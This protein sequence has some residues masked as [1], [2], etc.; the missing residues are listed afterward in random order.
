VRWE[1]RLLLDRVDVD[2]VADRPAHVRVEIAY[3]LRRTG[4]P[5][6]VGLTMEVGG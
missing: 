6:K 5:Q 1:P 2:E 3:R 4:L